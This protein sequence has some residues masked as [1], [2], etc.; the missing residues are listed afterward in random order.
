MQWRYAGDVL[1]YLA[2]KTSLECLKM[3]SKRKGHNTLVKKFEKQEAPT[4]STRAT[5]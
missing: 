5:Y 2:K 3:N 4:K 1:R